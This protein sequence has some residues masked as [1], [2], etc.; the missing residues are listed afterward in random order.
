M[1]RLHLAFRA[2]K[3]EH[4]LGISG[5]WN[6]AQV[7]FKVT[8]V[9]LILSLREWGRQQYFFWLST[10]LCKDEGGIKLEADMA[11]LDGLDG[12]WATAIHA[13]THRGR[14]T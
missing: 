5:N 7:R 9:H 12:S 6:H 14:G 10:Y 2:C 13:C 8:S 4:D 3:L 11:V 1:L